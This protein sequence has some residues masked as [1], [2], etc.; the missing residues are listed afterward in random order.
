MSIVYKNRQLERERGLLDDD[1]NE[2][3]KRVIC[4]INS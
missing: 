4:I 2:K 1:F 3:N